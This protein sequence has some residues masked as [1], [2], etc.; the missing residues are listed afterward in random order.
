MHKPW[1]QEDLRRIMFRGTGKE[2]HQ[3]RDT[4]RYDVTHSSLLSQ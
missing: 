2:S 3:T 4:T 1:E